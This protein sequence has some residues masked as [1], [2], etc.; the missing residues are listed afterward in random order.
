MRLAGLQIC[1]S[2]DLEGGAGM[3]TLGSSKALTR[4]GV[5]ASA[6]L[7]AADFRFSLRAFGAHTPGNENSRET[8]LDQQP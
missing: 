4:S 6:T 5:A 3:I 2:A 8:C 7:T 1:A